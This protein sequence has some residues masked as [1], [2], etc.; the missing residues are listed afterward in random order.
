MLSVMSQIFGYTNILKIWQPPFTGKESTAS[1]DQFMK[2]DL[3]KISSY[4]AITGHISYELI[5]NKLGDDL[6]NEY[7]ICSIIRNPVDRTLSLW[8]YIMQNPNLPQYKDVSKIT[9]E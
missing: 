4:H 1:V 7:L 3:Q 6:L 9:F 8:N 2:M 5:K